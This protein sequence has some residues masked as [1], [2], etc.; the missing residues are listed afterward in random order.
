MA[1]LCTLPSRRLQDM[2]GL[3]DKAKNNIFLN[4]LLTFLREQTPNIHL[5]AT[6]FVVYPVQLTRGVVHWRSGS[7]NHSIEINST[8]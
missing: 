4:T 8:S 5:G 3:M 6:N 2:A 7:V 1:N